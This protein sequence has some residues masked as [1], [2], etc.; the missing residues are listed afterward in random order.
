MRLLPRSPRG[1]W[2]LAGA[3]WLAV[4]AAAWPVL[5][6]RPRAEWAADATTMPV[7]FVPGRR[8]LVA[9]ALLS[10][11][12][13]T[14][15]SLRTFDADSGAVADWLDPGEEVRR[16]A[17]AISPDGRWA[18]VTHGR[19]G[20][21]RMHLFDPATGRRGV[22]L[23]LA[24]DADP[25]A[26]CFSPD[27]RWLAYAA[28]GPDGGCVHVWDVAA[29]AELRTVRP[30]GGR[31]AFAPDSRTLAVG[32]YPGRDAQAPVRVRLWDVNSGQLLREWN[33]PA[34][35]GCGHLQFAPDGRRLVAVF[36][37]WNE[38]TFP[39]PGRS[40]RMPWGYGAQIRGYDLATGGESFRIECDSV[41][42]PPGVCWFATHTY[43]PPPTG[44]FTWDLWGYDGGPGSGG[45]NLGQPRRLIMDT[46][47]SSGRLVAAVD[48]TV[49]S[50]LEWLLGLARI[51]W[52]FDRRQ[53]V[54]VRFVD[55][56]TGAVVGSLPR[57]RIDPL[58]RKW[59]P[60]PG[61]VTFSPARDLVAVEQDGYIRIW[62]LPPRQP[63]RWFAAAAGIL[64]L[65]FAGLAWRRARRLRRAAAGGG[66]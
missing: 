41:L 49:G 36:L 30:A 65:P 61:W 60:G 2:L 18:A 50:P 45:A 26:A 38:H 5:P 62:D 25:I 46:G 48:E 32:D 51:R 17:T 4:C 14:L 3:A 22:A 56:R 27:G 59:T 57:Q 42:A 7:G 39:N 37:A 55:V 29:G 13:D 21:F 9:G 64:A 11:E 34:C 63:L 15:S 58:E 33:G 35:R 31:L 24:A 6:V 12:D 28:N 16:R 43:P 20:A 44:D 19:A 23:P 53:T 1:T 66:R 8:A 47:G 54:G 40:A 10:V 52:P